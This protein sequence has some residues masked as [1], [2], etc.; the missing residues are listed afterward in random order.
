MEYGSSWGQPAAGVLL[1]EAAQVAPSEELPSAG[2]TEPVGLPGIQPIT[3]VSNPPGLKQPLAGDIQPAAGVNPELPSLGSAGHNEAG[4][5]CK[6]CSFHAKN[7]CT[8]GDK[9]D[10]CHLPHTVPYRRS[11][12]ARDRNKRKLEKKGGPCVAGDGSASS[13]DDAP[14][15]GKRKRDEDAKLHAGAHGGGLWRQP[16][17]E[18]HADGAPAKKRKLQQQHDGYA[19]GQPGTQRNEIEVVHSPTCV[20]CGTTVPTALGHVQCPLCMCLH[21]AFG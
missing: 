13:D 7:K 9:C 12:K 11:K 5:F 18:A 2:D 8:K 10:H 20:A 4:T 17:D 19:G 6:P 21:L 3:E 16:E 14:H 15:E 1:Q